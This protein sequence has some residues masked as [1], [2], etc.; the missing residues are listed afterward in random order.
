MLL[1]TTIILPGITGKDF[2]NV[3]TPR[4]KTCQDCAE[5]ADGTGSCR[6]NILDTIVAQ[7][8]LTSGYIEDVWVD[9]SRVGKP[10]GIGV[11]HG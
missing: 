1:T 10:R 3:A 7:D 5:G 11:L 6:D 8:K 9:G 2:L 4:E